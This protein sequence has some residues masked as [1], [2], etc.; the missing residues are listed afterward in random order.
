MKTGPKAVSPGTLYA[1]A[2]QAYWGFRYLREH[3]QSSWLAVKTARNVSE[4]Q[5][6]GNKCAA[7]NA[8][9]DAGYG[10]IGAM[11][12]LRREYVAQEILNAKKH[13]EYPK[14]NRPSSE[15]RR[16]IFLGVATAAGI[17][18]LKI[19]TALRKLAEAGQGLE[20]ISEDVHAF[21]RL[22]EMLRAKSLTWAEPVANYFWPSPNG[23]WI[24]LRDLPC[25]VP[26]DWQGGYFIFGIQ[27]GECRATFSRTLPGDSIM[28][29]QRH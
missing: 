8:M 15:D 23:G 25:E 24:L 17:F 13:S 21:D 7:R 14:S 10:V 2:H 11:T 22:K 4:I 18:E 6:I 5:E 1:F 26:T 19:A 16:M 3:E 12:W 9:P 28:R 27:E 29:R 20:N